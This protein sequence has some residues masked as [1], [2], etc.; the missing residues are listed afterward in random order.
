M[1]NISDI[2]GKTIAAIFAHPDDEAFGPAGTI[3]LLAKQNDVYIIVGTNGEAGE[4]HHPDTHKH[5]L[6]IRRHELISSSKVL[7]V[8]YVHFLDF[9]DGQLNNTIYGNVLLKAEKL[10]L[11]LKPEVLITF[12]HHGLTGHID[13]VFM[14]RVATSLYEGQ[15][16]IKQIWYYCFE[17]KM[18]DHI[19]NYYRIKNFHVYFPKGY[20]ADEVDVVV[21]V[22]ETWHQKMGAIHSHLSQKADR[23]AYLDSYEYA[24][25]KEYF[26]VKT[27][28]N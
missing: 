26:F 24:P 19:L 20:S 27:K 8:K 6:E 18:R 1:Q 22:S 13:H 17:K 15:P 3:A 10:M 23:Q 25:N 11:D 7:G 9:P 16:F 21:D 14:T 2:K 4:N 5:I 28:T 12:E